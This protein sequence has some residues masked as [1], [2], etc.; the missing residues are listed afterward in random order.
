VAHQFSV[1]D[2][3]SVNS[4]ADLANS[5]AAVAAF[6]L[7]PPSGQTFTLTTGQDTFAGTGHDVFNAPL[8]GILHNQPTLTDG[9]SLTDTGVNTNFG[10]VRVSLL[11]YAAS[12]DR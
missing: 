3:Q 1:L 12:G 11:G 2:V 9:D 5:E 10:P 7:N 8:S 4:S 6:V